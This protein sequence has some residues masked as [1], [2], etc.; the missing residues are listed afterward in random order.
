M[1]PFFKG[2]LERWLKSPFICGSGCSPDNACVPTPPP[3]ARVPLAPPRRRAA[4]VWLLLAGLAL[5]PAWAHGKDGG[6]G[7]GGSGSGSGRGGK[8]H[9]RAR[10]ALRSGAVLPLATLVEQL[11]LSHPGQ[12]LEVEFDRE[13][14]RLIYEVKLL[15]ANGQLLKLEVDAATG[16]VLKV[17]RKDQ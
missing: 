4:G 3:S 16:Q 9:E 7:S 13:D 11:K 8:D 14:G 1:A 12:V 10:D 17:R 2:L 5:T 15:H 6:G